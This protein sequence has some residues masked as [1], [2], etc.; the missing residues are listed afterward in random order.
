MYLR[1]EIALGNKLRNSTPLCI[2]AALFENL[3][4]QEVAHG[5]VNPAIVTL[6]QHLALSGATTAR[7]TYKNNR[8]KYFRIV[9]RKIKFGNLPM[10]KTI[11]Q[12]GSCMRWLL[13]ASP[14]SRDEIGGSGSPLRMSRRDSEN[15]R[16]CDVTFMCVSIVLSTTNKTRLESKYSYQMITHLLI[17][18]DVE[19]DNP[20]DT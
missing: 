17:L 20:R 1:G 19:N 16:I 6:Q 12:L 5:D 2:D 4:S 18:K 9:E 13:C 7:T 15:V 14:L 8:C 10:T 11:G 3:L